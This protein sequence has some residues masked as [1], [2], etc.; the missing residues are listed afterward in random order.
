MKNKKER[1]ESADF[2]EV[3]KEL[4]NLLPIRDLQEIFREIEN[5]DGETPQTL[6]SKIK[7]RSFTIKKVSDEER[8]TFQK[9]LINFIR[10]PE[11]TLLVSTQLKRST[12]FIKE[13][14]KKD[15]RHSL[16]LK[17]IGRAD[18]KIAFASLHFLIVFLD[19]EQNLI[20]SSRAL[21]LLG[22][23]SNTS[24]ERRKNLVVDL[25]KELPEPLYRRY[26]ETIWRLSY[27]MESKIFPEQ[28]P[29]FGELVIQSA[30]RLKKFPGLVISEMKLLRNSFAH[31]N[32]EYSLD[33]DSFTVWDENI[34]RTK[35]TAN[36]IVKIA[37]DATSICTETLPRVAQLYFLRNFL[38]DSGFLEIYLQKIPTLASGNQ[39]EVSKAEIELRSFM[40]S[41]TKPMVNFFQH[42]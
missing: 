13:N 25:F 9:N 26:L 40:E 22:K 42:T 36:L 17:L 15:S 4:F 16:L 32:F 31:N 5:F 35:M 6:L 19:E 38:A 23:I 28:S 20:L 7:N 1:E 29:K 34:P 14:L 37:N 33:D 24:K 27:L 11:Y 2:G 21:N 8:K 41:L 39:N 3:S 10:S 30:H 12:K 18:E